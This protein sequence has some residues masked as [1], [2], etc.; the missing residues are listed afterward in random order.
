ML[1]H[2]ILNIVKDLGSQIFA[3]IIFV[4]KKLKL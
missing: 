2:R 4:E 1:E 3:N